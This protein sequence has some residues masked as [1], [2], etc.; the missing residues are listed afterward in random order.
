M[1]TN[2]QYIPCALQEELR[3]IASA[4]VAPGKGILAADESP[5]SMEKRF[6]PYNLPNTEENR[7]QY[8]QL[9]FTT[10]NLQDY[11]SGVILHNETLY[12]KADNG[13]TF[14]DLLRH[15][16]IIVGIKVD[17][18]I[19]PLPGTLD[20]G[21]TEGLDD[22]YCRCGKYKRDGCDFAKWRCVL[23]IGKHTPSYQAIM[24]NTNILARY[25]SICQSQG[26]VPIVEPEVLVDGDHDI[27][28]AQKVTET[29]L[30]AQYKALN[31]HHVFLEGTLLKPNMIL[32]GQSSCRKNSPEEVA[33]VTVQ[34]FLRAV[35]AAVP[36]I[37]F[38]SGGQSEE[39]ATVHLNAIN[40]INLKRP[41]ELSF[42]Y[43]RALQA[44]AMAAWAGKK[45]NIPLGQAELKKRAKASS[46]ARSGKYVAGSIPPFKAE[47]S[48]FVADHK[49]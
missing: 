31:D 2:Y 6:S 9:M 12:Q 10:E 25:A 36:G 4:I 17:K 32:P 5:G 35:P 29:V 40:T 11:I 34:S 7:R 20:E 19:V 3:R 23:K 47:Q 13:K 26:I 48:L 37:V 44:S 21:T 45:E 15:R 14:G 18:G 1:G 33:Y 28:R 30:A 46:L 8:R 27:I 24:E 41:W 22:L 42:S 49:Y 16:G 39:E 43:G 38:L